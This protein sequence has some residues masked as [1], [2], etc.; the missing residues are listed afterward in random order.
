MEDRLAAATC[1]AVAQQ[2]GEEWLRS[3]IET[4]EAI[5]AAFASVRSMAIFDDS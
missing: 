3:E 1:I 5:R 4:E 2:V